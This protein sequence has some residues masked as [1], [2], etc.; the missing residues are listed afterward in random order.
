M[1][2]TKLSPTAQLGQKIYVYTADFAFDFLII[3]T[4]HE[5]TAPPRYYEQQKG[6]LCMSNKKGNCAHPVHVGNM[7][8][9]VIP[10]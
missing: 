2:T 9:F 6:K 5:Y 7:C 10:Y 3:K 4:C 1:S 8:V